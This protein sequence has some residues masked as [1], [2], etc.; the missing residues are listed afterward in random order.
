MSE[1]CPY[2]G[3]VVENTKA[4]GS[5]I[6]YIHEAESWAQMSQSRSEKQKERFQKLLDSCLSQ[7]GLPRPRRVDKLEQA[8][9]E[10]PEGVSPTIDRYKEAYRCAITKEELVREIEEELLKEASADE[11]K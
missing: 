11:T 2:C 3:K 1:K 4:L 10:I 6:H 5:H 8:V 9:T 7:R